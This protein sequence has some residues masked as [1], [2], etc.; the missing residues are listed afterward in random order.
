MAR[1]VGAVLIAGVLALALPAAPFQPA[2]AGQTLTR[3][4]EEY[5]R[6]I[7]R[8]REEKQAREHPDD[9]SIRGLLKRAQEYTERRSQPTGDPALDFLLLWA[10]RIGLAVG[11]PV[12]LGSVA[13]VAVCRARSWAAASAWPP[14]VLGSLLGDGTGVLFAWFTNPGE[15]GAASSVLMGAFLGAALGA[16]WASGGRKAVL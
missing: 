1:L 9:E 13:V 10:A 3:E 15:L 6:R 8:E 11:L 4:Q 5:L 14:I 2:Y 12:L 7:A 16:A